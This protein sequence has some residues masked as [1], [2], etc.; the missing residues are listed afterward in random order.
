MFC[1]TTCVFELKWGPGSNSMPFLKSIILIFAMAVRLTTG[2]DDFLGNFE[3][4]LSC[5]R[6]DS[7]KAPLFPAFAC[8]L[9]R[10]ARVNAVVGDPIWDNCAGTNMEEDQCCP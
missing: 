8:V 5:P 7:D 2:N 9:E 4:V 3:R 1:L 10:I 6:W